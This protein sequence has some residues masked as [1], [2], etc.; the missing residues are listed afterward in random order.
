MRRSRY[1][2]VRDL[3]SASFRFFFGGGPSG[4]ATPRDESSAF[5]GD[6]LP[7]SNVE[8]GEG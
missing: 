5:D 6:L 1:S 4:S 2:V 8:E 7:E 3:C